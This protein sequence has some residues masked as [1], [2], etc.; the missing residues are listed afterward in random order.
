MTTENNNAAVAV[1]SSLQNGLFLPGRLQKPFIK[2]DKLL[3]AVLSFEGHSET[4][5]L[6]IRQMSGEKPAERLAELGVGDS[7]W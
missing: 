6:H 1:P 7:S 3:G 2:G 5:L 4:A